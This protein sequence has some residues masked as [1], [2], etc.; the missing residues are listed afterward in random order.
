MG[1]DT[2]RPSSAY[3]ELYLPSDTLRICNPDRCWCQ[4]GHHRSSR[5]MYVERGGDG[6]AY[7]PF[8]Y[9]DQ[10]LA[11]DG[12]SPLFPAGWKDPREWT[13]R[14]YERLGDVLSEYYSRARGRQMMG[15]MAGP[16]SPFGGEE[17]MRPRS[18]GRRHHHSH[19]RRWCNDYESVEDFMKDWQRSQEFLRQMDSTMF[20]SEE[21]RRKEAWSRALLRMMREA[22]V[23]E[24]QQQQQNGMAGVGMAN[25]MM[26]MQGMQGLGPM[27]AG[28]GGFGGM[29]P[30]MGM[31]P[32][33][34]AGGM[35]SPAMQGGDMLGAMGGS[36]G[37]G[38]F[39]GGG[40]MGRRNGFGRP[41][42]RNIGFGDDLDDEFGG[43]GGGFGRRGRARRDRWE[44]DDMFGFG[45]GE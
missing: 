28:M 13:T 35:M 7:D 10:M 41:R 1:V 17:W 6:R 22:Q 25:P 33:G 43:G 8:Q 4:G 3:T 32:M 45:D 44:D 29:N 18:E 30:M 34:A 38:G 26:G 11:G 20:G 9:M 40:G 31:G 19:R 39:G 15:G 16:L 36:G 14:D 23:K 27:G 2:S 5:Y 24:M 42:R 12:D 21:E 37:G